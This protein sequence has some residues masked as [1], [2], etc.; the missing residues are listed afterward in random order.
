M[1]A[2]DAKF[3]PEGLGG[4]IPEG[5]AEDMAALRESYEHLCKLRDEVIAAGLLPPV[6]RWREVNRHL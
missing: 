1:M 3:T 6:E 5:D 4:R 2:A